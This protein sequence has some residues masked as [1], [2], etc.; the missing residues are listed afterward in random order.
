MSRELLSPT[1]PRTA[2]LRLVEKP[3]EAAPRER[4][5]VAGVGVDAL[6]FDA[7]LERL[8]DAPH[9]RRR[10]AVHFCA[11]HTFV[12]A[13][14][15]PELRQA[16]SKADMVTPDGMPV[17]W[18]GRLRGKKVERVCGPDTM[19]EVLDRSR[20]KGYRHFFYGG[21][22]ESLAALAEAMTLRFPGLQISGLYAPPFRP[23]TDEEKLR[24]T[25]LI[26]GANP[27]YVWVGIGSPKQDKWL[28]EF[29]PQLKA[30]VL[31]AVGAA[32]DFHAGLRKRAP[33]W[34]QRSGVEWVFRLASEPRRLTW[35][36]AMAGATFARILIGEALKPRRREVDFDKQ[37]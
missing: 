13:K 32:F 8:L 34:A 35:R 27:D 24:V 25:L 29:R 26:N 33:R 31:L 9:E 21:T 1:R 5:D 20:F 2:H 11:L 22:P 18:L 36:Y 23:L 10:M 15:D 7:A 19:L 17:V 16:L 28:A 6:R 3:V 14:K 37:W 4:F 30:S 12:E